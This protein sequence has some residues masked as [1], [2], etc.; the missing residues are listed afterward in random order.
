MIVI[1]VNSSRTVRVCQSEIDVEY[2]VDENKVDAVDD[3]GATCLLRAAFNGHMGVVDALVDED[4]QANIHHVDKHGANAAMYAARGGHVD[5][6]EALFNRGV[7]MVA[8]DKNGF[9][10]VEYAL[11]GTAVD[12]MEVHSRL[13]KLIEARTKS[14]APTGRQ[15]RKLELETKLAELK[16]LEAESRDKKKWSIE[17]KRVLIEEKERGEKEWVKE[18]DALDLMKQRIQKQLNTSD[19]RFE[20]IIKE[21][22]ESIKKLQLQNVALVKEKTAERERLRLLNEEMTKGY[23]Q[24]KIAF[25]KFIKGQD[26]LIKEQ[27]SLIF[28][29]A[30]ENAEYHRVINY[31][32]HE[33]KYVGGSD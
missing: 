19:E 9:T 33:L 6:V 10:V 15:A 27:E 7:S 22:T 8:A 12:R 20:A 31:N 24:K 14:S 2:V 11:L 32:E 25:V 18:T 30:R 16:H 29:Y 1:K 4:L 5:T 13:A 28:T 21:N 17:V 26:K 3:E 23:D